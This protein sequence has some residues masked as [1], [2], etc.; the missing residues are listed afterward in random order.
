[1]ASKFSKTESTA[2]RKVFRKDDDANT[3]VTATINLQPVRR[4]PKGSETTLWVLKRK[5]E[6]R[7]L[8]KS[9]GNCTNCTYENPVLAV[10]SFSAV[11]GYDL[12]DA[13]KALDAAVSALGNV[14]TRALLDPDSLSV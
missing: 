12:T 14:S 10:L 8:S 6:Y 5:Y 11:V 7:T 2:V 13:K 3:A 4:G 1:M 9:Q